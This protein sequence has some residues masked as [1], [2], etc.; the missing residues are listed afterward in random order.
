MVGS[1]G[2]ILATRTLARHEYEHPAGDI[3]KLGKVSFP[4][5]CDPSV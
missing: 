5:S 3:G 4:I 1:C 2:S